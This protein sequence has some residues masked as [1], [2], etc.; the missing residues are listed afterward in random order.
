MPIMKDGR[1]VTTTTT[2]PETREYEQRVEAFAR[3]AIQHNPE[4]RA[5]VA[6]KLPVRVHVHFVRPHWRGDLDNLAKGILD[7]MAK[8]GVF[9]N[10]NRV[11][12]TL[13]SVHTDPRAEHRAEVLVEPV[14]GPL[15][16]PLW[17]AIARAHGWQ[18][19]AT[20]RSAAR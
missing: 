3:A 8:A 5:V 17:M 12:Q 2:P 11:V 1:I 16:E 18:P 14:M 7:G 10:D 20:P 6:R 4:W 9:F 15:L 13:A 19:A